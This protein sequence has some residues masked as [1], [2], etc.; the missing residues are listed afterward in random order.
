[1]ISIISL[2]N[3]SCLFATVSLIG[4]EIIY[5]GRNDTFSTSL[6]VCKHASY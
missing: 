3:L 5:E 2:F 6:V 1:V 4:C